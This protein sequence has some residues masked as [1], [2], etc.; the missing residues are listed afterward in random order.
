M[1]R[2]LV[3]AYR[4]STPVHQLNQLQTQLVQTMPALEAVLDLLQRSDKPFLQEGTL[5]CPRVKHGISLENVTFSYDPQKPPTLTNVSLHLPKGHVTA[6]V[7]ASGAGKSTL[8]NLIARLYEPTV[9]H[10]YVDGIDLQMFTV[11][12]W[13][14]R[15][16]VVNQEPFLFHDTLLANL[17]FGR[18]D[19]TERQIQQVV[20]LAQAESFVTEL[21][22]GLSTR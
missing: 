6:L 20:A 11:A 19:A 15:L 2:F 17:R 3:L 12:S 8:L 5:P 18:A 7:G 9:G 4:L 10:L 13:R 14:A 22:R 21:P 16:A 1:T